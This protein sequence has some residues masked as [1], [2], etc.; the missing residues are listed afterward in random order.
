[1]PLVLE[2][3]EGMQH[4]GSMDHSGMTT[5]ADG[6]IDWIADAVVLP[7]GSR[8]DTTV[9]ILSSAGA[10]LSRQRFAFTLSETGIEDGREPGLFY[11]VLTLAGVLAAGGA[12]A[13]GLGIGGMP[14]PRCE[15]L[16]S[17][18]ALLGGGAVA[19]LLGIVIGATQLIA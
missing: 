18:V 9:R 6:T 16:A 3:M 14:L 13:L 17:R 5:G 19:M 8:W 7:R 10:E 15:S 11:V 12:V 2:G 4:T 1:M